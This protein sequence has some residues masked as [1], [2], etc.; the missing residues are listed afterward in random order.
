MQRTEKL[1]RAYIEACLIEL[2]ALKPGNV[3][4]QSEGHGMTVA[5]F[6]TSARVSAAPLCAPGRSVG[7]RIRDAVAAT[8]AAVGCN[9]NLGIVLLA[10][11]LIAAAESAS[12]RGLRQQLAMTLTR[13]TVA[14]AVAAYE[15]IRIAMP[16]GLGRAA[17]QD[18]AQAPTI[19]L[20]QAMALAAKRDL[21]ARQYADGYADVF[22]IGVRRLDMAQREGHTAEWGATL[23]HMDFLAAFPDSHILRKHGAAAAEAVRA[24]A[25]A[26]ARELERGPGDERL[27]AALTAFDRQLKGQGLNPGS[28][29]D[30]TVVSL[31]ALACEDML[32]SDS[33][34]QG[35]RSSAERDP[36]QRDK[37][38]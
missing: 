24:E 16:A 22:A 17:E 12:P 38:E 30:L 13:L 33:Q 4:V 35:S 20:R 3:H 29:A 18:V 31:L 36:H 9:T 14:D 19:G 5:Q 6:E 8:R 25:A 26:L 15:A 10:A 27:D 34:A 21:I 32:G 28:S 23:A 7:A 1:E 2:R 37:R 11:P